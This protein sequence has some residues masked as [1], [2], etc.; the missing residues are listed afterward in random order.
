MPRRPDNVIDPTGPGLRSQRRTVFL[1]EVRES[2]AG[3]VGPKAASLARMIR[4]GLPVP[5]G[6]CVTGA[7][8]REHVTSG[9][10]AAKV[11]ALLAGLPTA[12]PEARRAAPSAPR[13]G[14]DL[15]ELLSDLRKTIA[16]A[17]PS[18][19]LRA[20]MEES[21]GILGVGLVAVRSSATAEDLP[22]RSFAGQYDTHLGVRGP[23]ECLR[24]VMK[25]WASGAREIS[26]V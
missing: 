24:G 6:F 21:L 14:P 19:A 20:E 1:K 13:D 9:D 11:E 26:F 3:L 10:L 12:S 2:D 15:R 16:E 25:C 7:A 8:Y 17:P 18:E 22:G 5:P 4:V 23:K